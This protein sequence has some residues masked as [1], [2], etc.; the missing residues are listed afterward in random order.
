MNAF[1]SHTAAHVVLNPEMVSRSVHLRPLLAS[2]L[3]WCHAL[4]CGPAGAR[5]RYRGRTPA[6]ETVAADLWRSVFAQFVASDQ[7]GEPV[8]IVGLYNAAVDAGRAH[9]F[10]VGHLD[11]GTLV[12]EAFGLLCSWAFR[13]HGFVRIFIETPEFNLE[14]FASLSDVAV[15]EGRLRNYEVWRGRLWDLYILSIGV[16]AFTTRFEPLL[17]RRRP[18]P[19]D[20][21]TEASFHALVAELWPLDSLDAVEVLTAA[22]ELVNRP[23][24]D[25]I[26]TS[27]GAHHEPSGFSTALLSAIGHIA[28]SKPSPPLEPSGPATSTISPSGP[29][30]ATLNSATP[31]RQR[32][33]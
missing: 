7:H 25:R 19:R 22:E 30:P 27:L 16:E 31:V 8:G 14:Q 26:L 2:D 20:G 11:R 13:E 9:A 28:G 18:E 1:G 3:E 15:V 29:D 33:T 4:M 21:S 24:D 32:T 23:I 12:T 6:P 5:W 17:D 10:A